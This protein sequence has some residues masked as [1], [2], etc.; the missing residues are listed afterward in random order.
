M[1]GEQAN[2]E[3]F[4]FKARGQFR[5]ISPYEKP[6]TILILAIGLVVEILVIIWMAN[7]ATA[8]GG[9]FGALP[10]A[11]ALIAMAIWWFVRIAHLGRVYLYE[12]DENE[13][14]IIRPDKSVDTY[15]Y[16]DMDGI[17]Y[18]PIHYVNRK[19]RGFAVTVRT[20]YRATK[21]NYIFSTNKLFRSEGDTPFRILERRSG[22]VQSE[23]FDGM[24]FRS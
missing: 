14:R 7:P 1:T 21:Y 19:H 11:A 22:L 9:T 5:C 24:V 6:M 13:F 2:E 17:D 10:F 16:T 18:K 23:P 3:R 8:L 12:A 15:Y 20:K 4:G